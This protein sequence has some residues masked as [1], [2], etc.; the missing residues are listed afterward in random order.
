MSYGTMTTR[1][2]KSGKAKRWALRRA[3]VTGATGLLGSALVERL[4]AVRSEVVALVHD[5]PMA[6]PFMS[7]ARAPYLTLVQGNVEDQG[8]LQRVLHQ[9]EITDFFHLAAQPL[10]GVAYMNPPVT[11]GVN[12]AGTWAALEAARGTT[13]LQSFVLASSDKAYGPSSKLPYAEDMA[14][15]AE[16]PYDVSKVCAEILAR[17]YARTY[18]LPVGITRCANLYGG[19]DLNFSRIIPGTF[20]ALLEG[21][22]PIIRSDGTYRRQYL[23]VDDAVEGYLALACAL[24]ERRHYCG[25]SAPAA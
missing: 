23:Y 7:Y 2:G 10:V 15:G 9:Y 4:L 3:F 13:S 21:E 11:F 25:S 18:G 6:S 14:L 16:H 8:L 17:S 5:W 22:R 19:G 20:K 24:R 1:R 12:I